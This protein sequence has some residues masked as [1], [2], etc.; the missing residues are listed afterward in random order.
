MSDL[1]DIP[2]TEKSIGALS[3]DVAANA[4]KARK[5]RD[6]TQAVEPIRQ[7]TELSPTS[8]MTPMDMVYQVVQSGQPIE[9]VREMMALAREIKREQSREAFD[10]AIS[11]AKAQITPIVRNATGHNNKRY[12]DFSAIAR[13]IDP[14]LSQHGFS[15]RY[16]VSQSDRI[17]VTCILSH[18]GGH[19]EE[20]TLSAPSDTSGN[21]N[22]IQAIGSTLTYLQRY[23]LTAAL[24]LAASNDDDGKAA[25]AG[26]LI[27]EDQALALRDLI[28]EMN[29]DEAKFLRFLKLE[30]LEE[31]QASKYQ[32]CVNLLKQSKRTA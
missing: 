1:L 29:A 13:S 7:A 4:D 8:T 15:Y 11:K 17:T 31:I 18:E 20:T 12:A 23:S 24:G 26:E 16:K 3:I 6:M 9:V 14:I 30:S 22:A 10:A 32:E 19:A 25:G 28:L 2:G 27:S 5:E 21:K